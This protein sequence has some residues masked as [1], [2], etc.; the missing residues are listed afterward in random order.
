VKKNNIIS[1]FSF[2]QVNYMFHKL[3]RNTK[4]VQYE[5]LVKFC[6]K[7]ALGSFSLYVMR[8]S[9]KQPC[10]QNC[11]KVE[12]WGAKKEVCFAHRILVF[13]FFPLLIFAPGSR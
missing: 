6:S 10:G 4:H 5:H 3:S 8:S 7:Q 1:I 12:Q 13:Y 9:Y 11:P 2:K